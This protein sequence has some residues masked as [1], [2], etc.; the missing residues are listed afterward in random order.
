VQIQADE[1][2]VRRALL[3]EMIETREAVK[4]V[5]VGEVLRRCGSVQVRA[6]GTSMLPALWPGDLLTIR[7]VP[8]EEL[9]PGQ[10]VLVTRDNRFFIHRLI[11]KR[12]VQDR[13]FW[14]TKGDAIPNEDS[15]VTESELL[16]RVADVQR[17]GRTFIPR[18]EMSL[19][20]SSLSWMLCHWSRFRSLALRIHASRNPQVFASSGSYS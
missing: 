17:G 18:R 9:A 8:S 11:E 10:M 3:E 13:A 15:P 4:L 1:F 5:L 14:I 2:L 12:K 20:H 19:F 6:W 7:A 16:G